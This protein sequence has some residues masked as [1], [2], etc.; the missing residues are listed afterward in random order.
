MA[1]ALE[2]LQLVSL[3]MLVTDLRLGGDSGHE[4]IQQALSQ[5]PELL[6]V[7]VSVNSQSA[8]VLRAIQAGASAYLTKGASREELLRALSEVIEGRS[9]LHAEIAH[10]V[11][12]KVRQPRPTGVEPSD[13]TPREQVILDMLCQGHAPKEIGE[14]LFLSV[15]TVKTHIRSL[16]RKMDVSSRTQLV[17]KAV[18]LRS[19]QNLQ[20]E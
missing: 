1:E 14:A 2:K 4:L 3:D 16:Y 6:V 5:I 18:E 17:L 9:F 12:E 20:P 15:S 8:D 7:V 10:V 13:H 19:Q 11:F